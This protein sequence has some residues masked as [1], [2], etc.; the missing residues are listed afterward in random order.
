MILAI[1]I[2]SRRHDYDCETTMSQQWSRTWATYGEHLFV[3]FAQW[4]GGGLVSVTLSLSH[5][6]P[7]TGDSAVLCI[8]ISKNK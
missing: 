1:N 6:V 8:C 7:L 3:L 2:F 5:P 4:Q